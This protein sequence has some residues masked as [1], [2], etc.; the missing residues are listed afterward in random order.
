MATFAKAIREK[1]KRSPHKTGVYAYVKPEDSDK[2]QRK[3][4]MAG[5]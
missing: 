5:A 2:W 3:S 1:E 4:N